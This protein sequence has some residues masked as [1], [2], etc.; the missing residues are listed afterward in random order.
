MPEGIIQFSVMPAGIKLRFSHELLHQ[1]SF[2]FFKAEKN[3]LDS[4]IYHFYGYILLILLFFTKKEN[5]V[6]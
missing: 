3:E 6:I 1:F 2:L 4:D 5:I